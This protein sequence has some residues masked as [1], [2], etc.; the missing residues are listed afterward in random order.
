[1][2]ARP[3]A[4]T[5]RDGPP[6]AHVHILAIIRRIPRGRVMTYGDVARAAGLPRRA[7][8]VG[9]VLRHSPLADG[10]PWH[11]VVAAPG[12]IAVRDGGGRDEQMGRLRSEGVAVDAR[13]RVSL[14]RYA[15][16]PAQGHGRA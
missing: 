8:L 7:R 14:A 6:D 11:R 16:R 12:R 13:G 5:D 3:E 9:F 4:P 2:P 1:M 15:W 10:V